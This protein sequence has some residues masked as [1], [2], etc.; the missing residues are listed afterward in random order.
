MDILQQLPPSKVAGFYRRLALYIQSKYP[1][2]LSALLLLH[3]LDGK[4][5]KKTVSSS[6]VKDLPYVN[7]YLI[8][9]VR[10]VFLTQRQAKIKPTPIWGGIKP[11]IQTN[12][13]YKPNEIKCYQ[14]LYEG[15]AV[16][17]PL[18]VQARAAKDMLWGTVTIDKDLDILYAL[19]K[20]GLS[21]TVVV[22]T[23]LAPD[24]NSKYTVAF[25]SWNTY[26]K[27]RYDWD[28]KKHITVPNPDYGS[29]VPDA[30]SPDKKSVDVYH[31]NAK[32]VEAAGLAQ[33]FDV[34][35]DPW[36]VTDPAISGPAE[37]SL[38]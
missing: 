12:Q 16:E 38:S 32:R 6:Y 9:E 19:H 1:P 25:I 13:P 23:E 15:P 21:T 37:I 29:A 30:I 18:G 36:P 26:M 14:I 10:P 34:V 33:P 8:S 11:R 17:V 4:G 20:F 27:D 35:S 28:P 31:S 5:L 2:A 3:W 24:S 7:D 22:R